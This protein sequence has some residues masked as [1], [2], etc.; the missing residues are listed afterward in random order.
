MKQHCGEIALQKMHRNGR[1]VNQSVYKITLDE[2]NLL[3]NN[4][5]EF[6]GV[7]PDPSLT[8]TLFTQA[9]KDHDGLITYGE[10]FQFVEKFICRPKMTP[11]ERRDRVEGHRTEFR[12]RF[13]GF[14]WE[15]LMRIL[16]RYDINRSGTVEFS[17]CHR[18]LL[19]IFPNIHPTEIEAL[20]KGIFRKGASSMAFEEFANLLV[21]NLFDRGIAWHFKGKTTLTN[22]E[23]VHL[24]RHT[25]GFIDIDRVQDILL[26]RLFDRIDTNGDGLISIEEYLR[27]VTHFLAVPNYYGSEYIIQDDDYNLALG[28]DYI[29]SLPRRQA[30]ITAVNRSIPPPVESMSHNIAYEREVVMR[31]EVK[32]S[33]GLNLTPFNFSSQELALRVRGHLLRLLIHFDANRNRTFEEEEIIQILITLMKEDRNEIMYVISNVFRYDKNMDRRVTLDELADFFL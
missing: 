20:L 31:R 16:S 30:V 1:I 21:F 26:W 27:W 5:Y 2:F 10:Y 12:S 18:M 24:L 8:S 3:L 13:R 33:G 23:F 28:N 29:S 25:L 6:L 32:T 17:E 15:E 11:V 9:D 19:E 22:E 4:A 14:L 7:H